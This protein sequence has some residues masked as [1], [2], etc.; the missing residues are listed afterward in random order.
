MRRALAAFLCLFA[1]G[2]APAVRVNDT[3]DVARLMA[4]HARLS[5]GNAEDQ[6]REMRAADEG[7]R[8]SPGVRAHLRLALASLLPEARLRDAAHTERLLREARDQAPA[9]SASRGLAEALIATQ[10]ECRRSRRDDERK[11]DLLSAQV[12]EERRR[13]EEAAQKIEALRAIERELRSRR[14]VR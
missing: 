2:C 3:D 11:I 13:S 5:A 10:E 6:R 4:D 12:R 14:A 9:G 8:R 1:V 7:L